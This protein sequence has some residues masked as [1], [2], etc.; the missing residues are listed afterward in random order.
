MKR[1]LLLAAALTGTMG[2]L[3]LPGAQGQQPLPNIPAPTPT[4]VFPINQP[5]TFRYTDAQGMGSITFVDLGPDQVTAFDLLRVSITQNGVTYNG[6]GITTP[7][8]GAPRPL[9]NLVSFSVASP[10]GVAYFFQ[11]KMGLGVEFQG[12]G[13][14]FPVSDP[15]QVASWGLLFAPGT[16]TP[17]PPPSALSLSIDRGCGSGYPIGGP[18]V[19]T[20]SA[21]ANDTLSLVSYRSDGTQG[22]V[23]TNQPVIGGQSYSVSTFVSNVPG[24]RTLVLSDTAGAQTTCGFTGLN[25]Q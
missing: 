4:T 15:T 16:P 6:S 23:F 12:N 5:V 10:N 11:G 22:V 1:S 2:L 17:G 25:N 7:I 20:Y 24:Q 14:Y 8:P 3:A 21:A 13:T 19:I 9:T 18:I